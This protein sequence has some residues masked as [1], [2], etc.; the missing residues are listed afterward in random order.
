MAA[1]LDT[2]IRTQQMSKSM[3][4]IVKGMSKALKSLDVREID[5][6]MGMFE[7]NFDDMDERTKTME[8]AIDSTT[9]QGAPAQEVDA[10]IRM[11]ADEHNLALGAEMDG[12]AAPAGVLLVDATVA[13]DAAAEAPEKI[14]VPAGGDVPPEAPPAAPT[15]APAKPKGPSTEDALAA[16]LA[17]LRE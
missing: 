1:R 6:T 12:L 15:G 5:K 17:K 3:G 8:S 9:S 16:R 13:D 10:L 7:A 14:A 11:V 2:A 4:K